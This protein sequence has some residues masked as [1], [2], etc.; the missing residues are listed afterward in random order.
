MTPTISQDGTF[1][2]NDNFAIG[3]PPFGPHTTAHGVW[4]ATGPNSITADYLFM[5][6]ASVT[7]T[8][9]STGATRFRWQAEVIDADT[10]VG[11]VNVYSGDPVPLVWESLAPDQYPTIPKEGKSVCAKPPQFYREPSKCTIYPASSC[12]LIFKFKILRVQGE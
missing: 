11:Y 5:S 12:P 9:P 3:G 7:A 6:T 8:F 1:L 2:G 4:S 10:M